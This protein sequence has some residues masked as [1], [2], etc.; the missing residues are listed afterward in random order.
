MREL[1]GIVRS[2]ADASTDRTVL[3]LPNDPNV[4][5]WFDRPRPSLSSAIIFVDQ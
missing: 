1:V 2:A 5:A 3:L 4:E